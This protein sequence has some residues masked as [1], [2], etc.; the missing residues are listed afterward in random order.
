[1]KVR[2][3]PLL[4]LYRGNIHNYFSKPF[5]FIDLAAFDFSLKMQAVSTGF[6]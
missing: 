2:Q 6:S 3:T 5:H 4:E 1:M